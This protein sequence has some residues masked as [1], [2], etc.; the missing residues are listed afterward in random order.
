MQKIKEIEGSIFNEHHEYCKDYILKEIKNLCSELEKTDVRSSISKKYPEDTID[1]I[2]T[3][4]E[5]VNSDMIKE[6]M[7]LKTNEEMLR[8]EK[9]Y[10]K[11]FQSKKGIEDV[12]K[13]FVDTY[14]DKFSNANINKWG[15]YKFL[16]YLGIKVC[17]YC[18]ENYV[19]RFLERRESGIPDITIRADLDHFFTKEEFPL[20]SLTLYNLVPSCKICNSSIKGRTNFD[21]DKNPIN[22]Y[23]ENMGSYFKFNRIPKNNIDRVNIFLGYSDEFHF[24]FQMVDE[25]S[26]KEEQI[27]YMLKFFG[28]LE[29]YNMQHKGYIQRQVQR[30]VIYNE[31]YK[32]KMNKLL[33]KFEVST[34][35]PNYL[36]D[37]S[38]NEQS[39]GKLMNDCFMEF[40]DF[41]D[42]EDN[43]G[44]PSN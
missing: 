35:I 28:V 29:R 20:L 2:K 12:G 27:E 43:V 4:Y 1:N 11:K 10:R 25:H 38:I 22:P 6:L 44:K 33:E 19:Y 31:V 5:I 24:D 13:V 21:V 18:N 8:T 36:S 9:R 7:C 42:Y 41:N 17:P 30:E 32:E 34:D 3:D 16:N 39:L 26:Q 23:F 37:F 15:A 14:K 40:S